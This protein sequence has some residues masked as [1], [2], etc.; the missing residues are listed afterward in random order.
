MIISF[1][2]MMKSYLKCDH[3]NESYRAVLSCG[4]VYYAVQ[5]DSN[6]LLWQW[7]PVWPFKWKLL[8]RTAFFCAFFQLTWT[9]NLIKFRITFCTLEFLEDLSVSYLLGSGDNLVLDHHCTVSKF[10][11]FLITI[12]KTQ[13]LALHEGFSNCRKNTSKT[14]FKKH[15]TAE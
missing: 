4:A 1:E 15:E 9:K 2:F 8:S 7:N 12:Q 3:S 14:Y 13:G 11:I 6:V 5:G 10:C